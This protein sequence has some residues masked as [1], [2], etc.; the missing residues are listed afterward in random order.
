MPKEVNFAALKEIIHFTPTDVQKQILKGMGRFT[1]VASAKRLG[2]TMLAAYLALRE[3]F[4]PRHMVWVLGPNYELASRVWDYIEEWI[5][6][7]FGGEQGPFRI[8]KHDKIIENNTTGAKLWMKTSENPTS[9]LG[10]GLDLVVMDEA[11]R[12]EEGIWEGYIQPNLLDKNGRALIISNPFGFNWFYRMYLRGTPEGRLENPEYISFSFPTAVEDDAGNIIGTN[13]PYAA[14]VEELQ[15]L[16]KSLPRDRWISEYLG[17]FRE[18]AGQMFKHIEPC[19]DENIQ[20]PDPNEWFE[21]PVSTHLYSIGVDIA[22]MEDFTVIC[23]IDKMTHRLVGFWRVNNVSW[24]LM[25]EKIKESSIRY[26]DAEI[27]LDATG[28][29]GDIFV[30]NLAE[31]GVN[32]DTEF[33]YTNRTKMLLIDKLVLLMERGQI[34]FPRIPSLVNELKS[35]TY[36]I[37]DSGNVKYGS[38][39]QDDAVNALAL[40]CWNLLDVPLEDSVTYNNLFVPKRKSFN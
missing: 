28:N 14:R 23:I 15:A 3:M 16:K 11:A 7:Y 29:A 34:R 12:I 32:V 39:R 4:M 22:K 35:F 20:V 21:N 17:A 31:I 6:M 36:H 2:K 24:D 1:V 13:N 5:D 18:G 25:R 19:I 33:V 38:S 27:I 37:T 40:A 26:N 10:K 8:N 30:E 9:L